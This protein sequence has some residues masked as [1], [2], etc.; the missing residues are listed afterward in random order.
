[1]DTRSQEMENGRF[2]RAE[3][4][5][6]R[7]PPAKLKEKIGK[8]GKDEGDGRLTCSSSSGAMETLLVGNVSTRLASPHFRPKFI[9][10]DAWLVV[11]M[12]PILRDIP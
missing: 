2:Q 12:S 5:H 4:S 10:K 9:V 6:R 3:K 1:M 11:S 8:P 7:L